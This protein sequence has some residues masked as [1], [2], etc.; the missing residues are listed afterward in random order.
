VTVGKKFRYS[1]ESMLKVRQLERDTIAQQEASARAV[2][3]QQERAAQEIQGRIAV[4]EIEIR[5]LSGVNTRI[6]P[7]R[8]M[9]LRVYLDHAR[10][11]LKAKMVEVEQAN[12]VHQQLAKQLSRARQGIKALERHR[13]HKAEEHFTEW[14]RAEQK[15]SD[16]LWLLRRERKG[17]KAK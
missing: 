2:L 1:L 4:T 3:Q 17:W 15:G 6:E 10:D 8:E 12:H 13:E 7:D 11:E 5:S 14:Q 16:D 9:R